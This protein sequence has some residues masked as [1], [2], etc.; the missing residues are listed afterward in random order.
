MLAPWRV[1]G[2]SL[3]NLLTMYV[4]VGKKKTLEQAFEQA[5]P[6]TMKIDVIIQKVHNPP[7]L[8][9]NAGASTTSFVASSLRQNLGPRVHQISSAT[10]LNSIVAVL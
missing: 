5:E 3:L 4:I 2:T 6:L 1:A 10:I 8:S 9:K 7:F